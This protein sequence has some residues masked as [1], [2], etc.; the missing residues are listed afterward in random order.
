MTVYDVGDELHVAVTFTSLSD[1]PTN[2]TAITFLVKT[3]SG[4]TTTY[5]NGTDSEVNNPETGV[6]TLDFV[7][8]EA[9]EWGWKCTGTGA[10]NAAV[11]GVV[12]VRRDLA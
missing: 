5:V 7:I 6:F 10:I 3:P 12:R 4:E 11:Q 1:T 8:T 9:G 2:P